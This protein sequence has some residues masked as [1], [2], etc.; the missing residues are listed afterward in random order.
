VQITGNTIVDSMQKA[1]ELNS[2]RSIL[3]Q[4]NLVD[5]L[6][7]NPATPPADVSAI[8]ITP[9]AEGSAVF[10]HNRLENLAV[11]QVAFVNRSVP[12]QFSSSGVGNAG[13]DPNQAGPTRWKSHATVPGATARCTTSVLQ[14]PALDGGALSLAGLDE[15]T[16]DAKTGASARGG[17]SVGRGETAGAGALA[18][19]AMVL[20][21]LVRRRR[22]RA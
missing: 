20:A 22:R 19:I 16:T 8:D 5:G 4:H 2:G 11:G 7:R 12:G 1:I 15:G 21:A 3:L 9:D 10:N 18:M 13:F 6:W 17:C 14:Q